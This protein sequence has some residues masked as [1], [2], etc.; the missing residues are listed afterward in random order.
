MRSI[1]ALFAHAVHITEC[2]TAFLSWFRER[3]GEKNFDAFVIQRRL[4]VSKEYS[5][6]KPGCIAN[7]SRGGIVRHPHINVIAVREEL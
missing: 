3:R 5:M 4:H 7:L 1:G 6:I 2:I